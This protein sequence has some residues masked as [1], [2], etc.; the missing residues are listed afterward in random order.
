MSARHTRTGAL[1]NE[2]FDGTCYVPRRGWIGSVSPGGRHRGDEILDLLSDD[3]VPYDIYVDD[4]VARLWI[5][6]EHRASW[7][8]M[9]DA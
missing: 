6:G 7:A 5:Y 4:G 9:A 3:R 8:A 1:A 2:L